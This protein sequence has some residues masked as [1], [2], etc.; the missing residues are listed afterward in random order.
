[1]RFIRKGAEPEKL[2]NWRRKNADTV[3][4]RSF[5]ALHAEEKA[6]LRERLAKEQGN[7]CA[8]TMRRLD[9][10]EGCHFEHLL[11]QD[12]APEAAT[13]YRNILLC[14]PE[15]GP[16]EFGAIFKANARVD[17]SNFVSPLEPSCE[18]RLRYRLSGHVEAS[19]PAD[20]G[21]KR[22]IEIL[23]LNHPALVDARKDAIEALGLFS[24][25]RSPSLSSAKAARLSV[26]VLR[27]DAHD[28]L[29]P[30]CVAISQAAATYSKREAEHSR[31]LASRNTK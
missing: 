31:R 23:A 8:Y 10:P 18:A 1:M 6:D 4:L 11:S 7:I 17:K 21:A 26:D 27:P 5:D 9:A 12:Q 3:N 16:C 29:R 22:T 20:Y 30:Y 25:P 15:N 19:D 28:R 2:A 14:V 24:K 13:D